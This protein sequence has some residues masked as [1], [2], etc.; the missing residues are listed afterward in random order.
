[1]DEMK[2]PIDAAIE[3]YWFL[4]KKA[5]LADNHY[6]YSSY[7]KTV[8]KL[9]EKKE[10]LARNNSAWVDVTALGDRYPVY[11][12]TN[13][14]TP[15][16]YI[17]GEWA[18]SPVLDDMV[19]KNSPYAPT[20]AERKRQK[21]LNSYNVVFGRN[22]VTYAGNYLSWRKEFEATGAEFAKE[23]MLEAYKHGDEERW[24]EHLRPAKSKRTG[25]SIWYDTPL[26]Y[27]LV[28]VAL[29]FLVILLTL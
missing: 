8:T 20:E 3:H 29:F 18:Y 4:A 23:R 15:I 10:Y 27:L 2:Q 1:M 19:L 6:L 5:R 24:E 7:L 26:P 14:P 13:N 28:S 22:C 17:S 16:T 9:T 11:V 21:E 25:I 12:T